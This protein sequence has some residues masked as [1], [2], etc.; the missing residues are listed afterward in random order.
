MTDMPANTK[1]IAN[2]HGLGWG[3]AWNS[4]DD[5]MHFSAHTSE[6]G[7]FRFDRNGKIPKGPSNF[8]ETE[9]PVVDEEAGNDLNDPEVTDNEVNTPG[10]QNS[11]GTDN[12]AQ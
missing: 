10:P 3:G 8:N 4:L 9:T 12:N 11:D 2:K 7:S 5:A 6:G 1:E